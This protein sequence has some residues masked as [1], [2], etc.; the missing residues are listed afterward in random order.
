MISLRTYEQY[1]SKNK[2]KITLSIAGQII[3]ANY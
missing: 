1:S 2:S 3:E